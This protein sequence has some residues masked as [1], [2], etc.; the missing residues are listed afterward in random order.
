MFGT[1]SI[2]RKEEL[3][4]KLKRKLELQS[5]NK[6]YETKFKDSFLGFISSKDV[7][8]SEIWK[9]IPDSSLTTLRIE[10]SGKTNVEIDSMISSLLD[11]V[12]EGNK[13]LIERQSVLNNGLLEFN[14]E[15]F[16][17]SISHYFEHKNS[18]YYGLFFS[19]F[20]DKFVVI[21]EDE[22][23]R[24]V[25]LYKGDCKNGIIDFK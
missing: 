17:K 7:L 20:R 15:T 16:L 14:K 13:I 9:S 23:S 1:M 11:K 12:L 5:L 18:M 24:Y 25:D 8:T 19:Q 2:N 4:E 22:E 21:W 3:K 6:E 10:F